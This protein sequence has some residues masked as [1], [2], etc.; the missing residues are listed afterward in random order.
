MFDNLDVQ[1]GCHQR[2]DLYKV[3]DEPGEEEDAEYHERDHP[4]R[5]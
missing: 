4:D 3:V 5:H 2:A 1:L